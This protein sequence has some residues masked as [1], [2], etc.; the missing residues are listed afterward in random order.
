[1]MR[2]EKKNS[3]DS[4]DDSA[5]P[6]R[7][8]TWETQFLLLNRRA[9]C[10]LPPAAFCHGFDSFARSIESYFPFHS[11]LSFQ[12]SA[13]SQA[14]EDICHWRLSHRQ[15]ALSWNLLSSAMTSSILQGKKEKIFFIHKNKTF[16]I[17]RRKRQKIN[18]WEEVCVPRTSVC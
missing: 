3:L 1:M 17:D 12:L 9:W 6:S 11:S 2:R 10:K 8:L 18:P 7:S 14:I 13:V 5:W 16:T 4:F 15:L